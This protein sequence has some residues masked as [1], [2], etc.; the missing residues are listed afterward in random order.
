MS[1]LTS[2]A[3]LNANICLSCIPLFPVKYSRVTNACTIQ[4]VKFAAEDTPLPQ[5]KVNYLQYC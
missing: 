2:L 1:C 4:K 5:S 3:F